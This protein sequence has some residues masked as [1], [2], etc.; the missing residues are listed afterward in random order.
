MVMKKIAAHTVAFVHS[1]AWYT[2]E[3]CSTCR[4]LVSTACRK[5]ERRWCLSGLS[6]HHQAWKEHLHDYKA[7]IGVQGIFF[8]GASS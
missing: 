8:L 3:L 2:D 6:L 1:T 4:K 7:E 5:L